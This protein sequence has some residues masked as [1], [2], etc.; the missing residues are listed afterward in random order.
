MF[1]KKRRKK[2]SVLKNVMRALHIMKN[3]RPLHMQK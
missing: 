3:A 2:A 1:L